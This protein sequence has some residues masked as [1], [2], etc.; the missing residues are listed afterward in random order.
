MKRSIKLAVAAAV[1]LTA[2]SS[3]A[4]NGDHLIG[5]GAKARG[6]GGVG[7][8]VSHG[9][10]SALA[11]PAL[12]TSVKGT[13]VSFGGTIFM[14]KVSADMGAGY[15][16]SAS[17]LSMIPEVSLASKLS[18]N[19]YM[20]VGMWGT[21]GMGV[22]YRDGTGYTSNMNMVTNLQ[23]MQFGLPMAFKAAGFSLGVTP[24]IQYGALDINYKT[25]TNGDGTA[26]N[27][28]NG[29]AQD[30]AYGYTLGASYEISSATV[31]MVYK[32]PID[33]EYKGQL[34]SATAPFAAMGIFPGAMGDHLEQP[35]EIGVG[36]SYKMG[37]NTIAVD[38]KQIKWADAKG[39]K[40][41][42]W[43]NQNV[44]ALGYEYAG[45]GYAI[46]LGYNHAKSPISD[47]G[48]M[49]VA[50]AGAAA[51]GPNIYPYLGGN[52]MNMFNLLGFPA[53]VE[54]HYTLGGTY[55]VSKT[56]SFDLAYIYSPETTTTLMTMPDSLGNDH[57]TSVKHSQSALSVQLNY[58]F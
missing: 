10:E 53:I 6:M 41:F 29:V 43:D 44:L 30:I 25:D 33:M 34:S 55:E 8:G 31:G 19:F 48:A 14:P 49:T 57:T 3:F 12:I 2:T 5:L 28:G 46:R 51:G 13:E 37:G 47:A 22:D 4:T 38:Y 58:N 20:G 16:D 42:G 52:A 24:I 54:T 9:A 1:A 50:Q 39:Y 17:D 35:A 45:Q 27:Y 11:N 21:A 15:T 7:I 40:D 32:S 36:A 26:E 23:L 18:D 56:T